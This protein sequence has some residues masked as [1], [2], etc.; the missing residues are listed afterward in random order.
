MIL[1]DQLVGGSALAGSAISITLR[2]VDVFNCSNSAFVFT[3]HGGETPPGLRETYLSTPHLPL[4][5]RA[6]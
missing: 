3:A 1:N 6:S 4:S 2:A 5:S